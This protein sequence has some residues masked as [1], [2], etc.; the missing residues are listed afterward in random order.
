LELNGLVGD[1]LL[2]ELRGLVVE[3]M[4]LRVEAMALEETKDFLVGSFDGLFFAVGD[5]LGVNGVAI[6]V[7]EYEKIVVSAG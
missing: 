2:Q 4:E 1:E 5:G 3:A 6:I 7:I